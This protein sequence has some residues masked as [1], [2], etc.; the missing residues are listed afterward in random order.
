MAG[1]ALPY[2]TGK[3]GLDTSSPLQN[4]RIKCYSVPPR[5]HGLNSTSPTPC[6]SLLDCWPDAT[7]TS[8]S[9]SSAATS[10]GGTP[11]MIF[12]AFTSISSV[13]CS[14]MVL[15]VAILMLGAGLKPKHDPRPVVNRTILQPPATC[16]VTD[17][18]S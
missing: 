15:F 13:M 1:H 2:P 12:P 17:T 8:R 7:A 18:G 14:Y 4:H 9:S 11:S 3:T 16:P 10:S 5:L 6:A